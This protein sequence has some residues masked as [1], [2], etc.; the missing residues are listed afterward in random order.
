MVVQIMKKN[1][2]VLSIMLIFVMIMTSALLTAFAAGEE[3]AVDAGD[4]DVEVI[5]DFDFD[6][7][8]VEEEP[9][10]ED[11]VA[12]EDL[13]MVAEDA[14]NA[15]A[16]QS[17]LAA[18]TNLK[19]AP[20]YKKVTVTW[21]AVPGATSYA[22]TYAPGSKTVTVAK[23]SFV[24]KNPAYH[25]DY[26][27]KV[28]AKN[29]SSSSAAATATCKTD[30]KIKP[31]TYKFKMK[32]SA[33]LKSHGGSKKKLRLK[34]GETIKANRFKSGKY[35]ITRKKGTYFI[36]RTRARNPKAVYTRKYN[37][38]RAE[39]EHFVNG[40]KMSSKKKQLI[41]VST[42]CQHAYAFKGKKGKW[43]CVRDW[44]LSTGRA[45]APTPTGVNGKVS[46]WKKLSFRHGLQWWSCFSSYNAFH[47]KQSSWSI[48]K[49]ASSG[50]IR[51]KNKDAKWIYN[52]VPISTRVY[53][54]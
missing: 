54:Y 7:A 39:A 11:V 51:N 1:R 44:E 18:V 22:V 19:A 24:L 8:A 3:A 42:Y 6:D 49:P 26:T 17:Q 25:T 50:C 27:F 2:R 47:G 52:N 21:T 40:I 12:E 5:D 32:M 29:D 13:E 38:T 20:G 9:V 34:A 45:D 48:G 36:N 53:I 31:I 23:N 37:Y 41:W 10:A 15:G 35:V 30:R 46:L 4:Q 43:K 28:V 14:K 33:T 16:D